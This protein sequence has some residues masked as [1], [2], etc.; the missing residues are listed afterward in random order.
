MVS[1]TTMRSWKK[2]FAL[3]GAVVKSMDEINSY[4][5]LKEV[6]EDMT[7]KKKDLGIDGVFA[8]TSLKNR[9]RTGDGRHILQT[10]RFT[11]NTKI[12]KYPIWIRSSSNMQRTTRT[13]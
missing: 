8:S 10:F 4:D 7:A 13:F 12:T 6:V 5:K 3:D 11:M 1:F 2:Y 9:V